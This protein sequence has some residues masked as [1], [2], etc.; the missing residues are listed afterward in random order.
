MPQRKEALLDLLIIHGKS[1]KQQR[2]LNFCFDAKDHR[3]LHFA[4]HAVNQIVRQESGQFW[5]KRE[6]EYLQRMILL[7]ELNW[8]M[9]ITSNGMV[10]PLYGA[11][12]RHLNVLYFLVPS[13][14]VSR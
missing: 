9:T 11:F 1:S 8:P 7:L 3:N 4:E 13:L 5:E 6:L 10:G 14:K 2:W 12:V